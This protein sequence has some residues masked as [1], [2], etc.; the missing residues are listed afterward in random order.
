M[1]QN[2]KGMEININSAVG[3]CSTTSSTHSQNHLQQICTKED[4]EEKR[5]L[6]LLELNQLESDKF[7]T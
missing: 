2:Q 6:Q 3:S 7:K 1:N 4:Q 5:P